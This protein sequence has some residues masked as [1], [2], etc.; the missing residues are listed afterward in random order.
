MIEEGIAAKGIMD[1]NTALQKVLK[2]VLI[3]RSPVH[4]I[5]RAAKALNKHQAHLCVLAS[6]CNEPMYVKLVNVLSAEHQMN[7]IKVNDKKLRIWV[8]LCITD[9][10]RKLFK[11]IGC[12]SVV[13]KD[14]GKEAQAKDDI[15]DYFG[16][17][18]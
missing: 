17:K 10:E 11:V 18:K 5:H 1:I 3:H 14:Y 2:T 6:N 4:G 16:C 15:E 13:V 9:K 7:I 12:S 8:V